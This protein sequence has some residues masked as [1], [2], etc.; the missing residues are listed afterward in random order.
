MADWHVVSAKLMYMVRTLHNTRVILEGKTIKWKL[1]T[2][3]SAPHSWNIC[4]NAKP[5]KKNAL[6]S[7]FVT[8]LHAY[9]RLLKEMRGLQ[10]P[11]SISTMQGGSCIQET[12]G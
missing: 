2:A 1:L 11:V 5:T 10:H 8:V 7:V 9:Q 12:K 3:C 6:P 4:H